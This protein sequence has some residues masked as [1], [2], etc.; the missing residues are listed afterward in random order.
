MDEDFA[1]STLGPNTCVLTFTCSYTHV[2]KHTYTQADVHTN[3]KII[4]SWKD[5]LADEAIAL[6]A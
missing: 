5:G 6:Q 4:S 2:C 3:T 1:T